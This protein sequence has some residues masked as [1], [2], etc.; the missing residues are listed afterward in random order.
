VLTAGK[1]NENVTWKRVVPTLNSWQ[2]YSP[3][4]THGI[5]PTTETTIT[6]DKEKYTDVATL[7]V[8]Q[9]YVSRPEYIF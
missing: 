9:W 7:R 3:Y 5:L 1:P 2:M 8:A 6:A 4:Q